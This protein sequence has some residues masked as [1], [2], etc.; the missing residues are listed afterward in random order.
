MALTA[1]EYKELELLLHTPGVKLSDEERTGALQAMQGK[2]DEYIQQW[3][4]AEPEP[5]PEPEPELTLNPQ[6]DLPPQALAASPSTTH[7]EGDEAAADEFIRRPEGA[8]KGTV[9]VYEPPLKVAREML[10][11]DPAVGRMLF[12]YVPPDPED[13]AKMTKGDSLY[14]AVADH[15]WRKTAG[16]AAASGKTAYRYSQAPYLHDG[17]AMSAI[18]SLGMKAAGAVKPAAETITSFVMGLDKP[19]TLGAGRAAYEA[20]NPTINESTAATDLAGLAIGTPSEEVGGIPRGL[21]AREHDRMLQEEHPDAYA[22]GEALGALAPWATANRI[23]SAATGVARRAAGPGAGLIKKGLASFAGGAVGGGLTQAGTEAVGAANEFAEKHEVATPIGD[24]GKR[25]G[26]TSVLSGG[27]GLG[28]DALG[29]VAMKGADLIANGPRYR[30]IPGELERAGTEFGLMGPKLSAETQEVVKAARAIDADPG[31]M[32]AREI[33]P[34]IKEAAD[35]EVKTAIA[36]VTRRKQ[37]YYAT[38]E[39]SQRL[40]ATNLVGRAIKILRRK[41]DP[42]EAGKLQR[43]DVS[44]TT[45]KV[46]DIFNNEVGAVSTKP[47]K[48]AIELT[49]EEAEEFLGA[50]WRKQLRPKKAGKQPSPAGGAR[51]LDL[52]ASDVAPKGKRAPGGK[53]LAGSLRKRGIDKVYVTPRRHDAQAFE[54]VMHGIKGFRKPSGTGNTARE[55]QELNDAALQ[56]RDLRPRAGEPGGWSAMQAEHAE[57]LGA[58]KALERFV[59]PK[60]EPFK[61]LTGYGTP[62]KGELLTVEALRKAADKGGV[63][64]EL[65]HIR[66]YDR[67]QRLRAA[68]N[69]GPGING[70]RMGP[71][72]PSAHFDAAA[73][74]AFP[75]LRYLGGNASPIRGGMGGLLGPFGAE[76]L[77]E[78]D[79]DQ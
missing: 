79:K 53:G 42:N 38:E 67:T 17:K 32:M 57:L 48:D 11:S 77:Q 26:I 73:I 1:E 15:L 55:L 71:F 30:G 10:M 9:F 75:A 46:K 62:K 66:H 64:E 29:G 19:G 28:M 4:A 41:H 61:V 18:E 78:E 21:K 20:V 12:P 72:S 70:P 65:E 37:A 13:I 69:Y 3:G 8:S 52:D 54:E 5:E 33:A 68:A 44:G 6:Y 74:R 25:I 45:K 31:D 2:E 43:L 36:D 60:G 63:R 16:A 22:V 23:Y 47:V 34:A 76:L 7:P 24:M 39:G 14:Q 35:V 58:A 56:D 59:S 50:T 49:P 40:P 27:L 51:E